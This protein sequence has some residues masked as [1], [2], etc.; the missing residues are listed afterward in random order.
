MDLLFKSYQDVVD[1]RRDVESRFPDLSENGRWAKP[2]QK[3]WDFRNNHKAALKHAKIVVY[4]DDASGNWIAEA[5]P[6]YDPEIQ[7]REKL[8]EALEK[9]QGHLKGHC[10]LEFEDMQIEEHTMPHGVK[11]LSLFCPACEFGASS[12]LPYI[13]AEHLLKNV[14]LEL[15]I[16]TPEKRQGEV[17]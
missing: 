4:P 8:R 1:F 11:Q 12:A 17:S 15:R 7:K 13:L 6:L 10:G 9:W 2:S 16:R 3:F 14:G 5:K